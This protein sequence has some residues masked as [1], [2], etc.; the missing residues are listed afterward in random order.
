MPKENETK[1][2]TEDGCKG[3]LRYTTSGRPP[4][5]GAGSAAEDGQVVWGAEEQPGWE[6]SESREHFQA[7]PIG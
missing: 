6:C 5:W 3:T 4:G 2:C 7:E 1:P